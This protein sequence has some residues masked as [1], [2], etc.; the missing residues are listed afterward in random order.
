MHR[1]IKFDRAGVDNQAI[2]WAYYIPCM[3]MMVIMMVMVMGRRKQG[4][5]HGKGIIV[6]MSH[7]VVIDNCDD[8]L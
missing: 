3:I 5:G 4:Q 6:V 1:I 2:P 8:L 7:D